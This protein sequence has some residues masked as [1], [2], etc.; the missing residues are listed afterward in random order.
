MSSSPT[1]NPWSTNPTHTGFIPLTK[2]H[3]LHATISGPLRTP[4]TPLTII[5]PGVSATATEWSAVHRQLSQETRCLLYSRSG[6]GPSSSLAGPI[7]AV[8][9]ASE[10]LTLLEA[11]DLPGPYI[12][13]AHSWG[14]IIAR[15]FL[16]L[17]N[18]EVGGIV[19][20]DANQELNTT[21]DQWCSPFVSAMWK[22]VDIYDVTGIREHTSL[23]ASE[24]DAFQAEVQ[25]PKYALVAAQEM[26]A[27]RPSGPVLAAKRQLEAEEPVMGDR[28][29]SVIKGN[30]LRDFKVVY[31]AG[32][33]RGNGSVEERRLYEEFIEPVSREV[34]D[35]GWQRGNLRLS[36]NG[37]FVRTRGEWTGHNVHL[38]EPEIIV[39]EV[40]WV[41]GELRNDLDESNGGKVV[42]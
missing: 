27:Y 4:K 17:R 28:P 36:G 29:V 14:G 41:L 20:V 13:I 22:D 32:L 18:E 35:E 38:T 9:I 23:S 31:E 12:L 11:A 2:T 39:E 25:T 3:S 24:W 26:A 5:I 15:E 19:F 42:G 16:H 21:L 30:S 1:P 10:L 33:A 40:R 8:S 7:T 34:R 6:H 37:R